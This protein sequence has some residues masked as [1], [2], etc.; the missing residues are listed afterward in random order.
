MGA[1]L[2]G[3]GLTGGTTAGFLAASLLL[4]GA[5]NPA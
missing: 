1:A 4:L 3:G 5:M 2:R